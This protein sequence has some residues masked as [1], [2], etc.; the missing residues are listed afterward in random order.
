MQI[1][2]YIHRIGRSGR[3]GRKG[4]AINLISNDESRLM[5]EIESFYKIQV[6]QL[7]EDLSQVS[8]N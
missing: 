5:S 6:N 1:E 2:N 7:P 3:Y 8:F 4:T